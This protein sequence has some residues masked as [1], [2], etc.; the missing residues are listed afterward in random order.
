[1]SSLIFLQKQKMLR[2]P[3]A[4]YVLGAIMVNDAI[5]VNIVEAPLTFSFRFQYI[6][7]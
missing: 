5:M 2:I 1:M 6:Q 7:I 4:A 3:S